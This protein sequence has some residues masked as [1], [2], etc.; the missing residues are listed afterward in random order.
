MPIAHF[1]SANRLMPIMLSNRE[2]TPHDLH[3]DTRNIVARAIFQCQP[4][5]CLG[6]LLHRFG[7]LDTVQ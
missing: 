6:T 4:A 7:F 3:D 5:Q 1:C 2:S